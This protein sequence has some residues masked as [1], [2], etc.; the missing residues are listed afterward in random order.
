[1][2]TTSTLYKAGS[3]NNVRAGLALSAVKKLDAM[4]D[5]QVT[6]AYDFHMTG[7]A[8]KN[9]D[10]A[11][12]HDGYKGR[13][14]LGS[15]IYNILYSIIDDEYRFDV[16]KNGFT[17]MYAVNDGVDEWLEARIALVEPENILGARRLPRRKG[18]HTETRINVAETLEL[19]RELR[20]SPHR[21]R[22]A[23]V[24]SILANTKNE[25]HYSSYDLNPE[26]CR[27]FEH[28]P[29]FQTMH[30]ADLR[31]C[32]SGMGYVEV[33]A[34]NSIPSILGD[35]LPDLDISANAMDKV[36]PYCT[37]KSFFM[38]EYGLNKIQYLSLIFGAKQDNPELKEIQNSIRDEVFP[39]LAR[40]QEGDISNQISL[41]SSNFT[42]G[43]FWGS[44]MSHILFS[45]ERERMDTAAELLADMGFPTLIYKFDGLI[46]D[47]VPSEEELKSVCDEYR[48]LTGGNLTLNIKHTY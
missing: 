18:R 2:L 28:G 11:R 48:R 10:K 27:L 17:K 15:D 44:A 6:K 26:R 1:M 43:G 16:G 20:H 13:R 5:A 8:H 37:N 34:V 38:S 24:L 40:L 33:D 46:L 22:Y 19:A 31:R 9:N 7:R 32:L 29:G 3:D 41:S 23:R 30:K 4:S 35:F 45:M 25:I 12:S 39:A 47:S 14:L 36:L 42:K 21:R